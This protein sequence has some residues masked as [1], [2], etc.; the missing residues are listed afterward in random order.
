MFDQIRDV[1]GE[2]G[3]RAD[4]PYTDIM[5]VQLLYIGP[6]IAAE[7]SHE[8]AHLRFRTAPVLGRECV[9]RKIL[10]A[11]LARCAHH[12]A[13]GGNAFDMP[14]FARQEPVLGPAAVAIHDD[15]NMLGQPPLRKRFRHS[16]VQYRF[17]QKLSFLHAL[18]MSPVPK[19]HPLT[20]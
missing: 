8:M 1:G 15:R 7:Q 17:G 10:Q 4:E 5:P 14:R 20:S 11:E 13:D 19:E 18:S 9:E 3:T 6:A 2:T 16:G 12:L